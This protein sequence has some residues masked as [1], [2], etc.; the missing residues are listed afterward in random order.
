MNRNLF[1]WRQLEPFRS[2]AAVV[3][4]SPYWLSDG[5]TSGS[6]SVTW[7]LS[8][9]NLTPPLHTHTHTQG[10]GRPLLPPSLITVFSRG[11]ATILAALCKSLAFVWDLIS[12][13]HRSSPGSQGWHQWCQVLPPSSHALVLFNPLPLLSV[14]QPFLLCLAS[15]IVCCCPGSGSDWS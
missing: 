11:H 3:F 10:L 7:L 4:N 5:C 14:C 15:V 8:R 2:D 6:C 1:D 13:I 9:C 12:V